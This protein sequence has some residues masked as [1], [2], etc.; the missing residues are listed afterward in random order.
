MVFQKT[1]D[2][3]MT[4]CCIHMM[5][6]NKSRETQDRKL[7]GITVIL[8]KYIKRACDELGI[9]TRTLAPTNKI[10]LAPIYEY[11]RVNQIH[12]YDLTAINDSDIDPLNEAHI[13]RFILSH[14]NYMFTRPE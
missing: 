11:I 13:E 6:F 7:S 3:V 5:L 4:L 9:D 12:L 8:L 1:N 14:I 10:D 2:Y